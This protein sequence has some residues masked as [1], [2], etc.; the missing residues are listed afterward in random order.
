[1]IIEIAELVA[2]H[3][4]DLTLFLWANTGT[5]QIK[6][7]TAGCFFHGIMDNIIGVGLNGL[8]DMGLTVK[9]LQA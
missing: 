1:M 4:Y 3:T 2:A 8:Q 5:E 7:A 6:G 9:L